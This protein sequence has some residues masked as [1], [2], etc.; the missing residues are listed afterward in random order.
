MTITFCQLVRTANE[1]AVSG[2]AG[3]RADNGWADV[4]MGEWMDGCMDGWMDA[5][6][7][8]HDR[9]QDREKKGGAATREGDTAKTRTTRNKTL[10][11]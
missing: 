9:W 2:Q 7:A 5:S 3:K 11:R 6:A 4:R 8:A 1:T 10:K